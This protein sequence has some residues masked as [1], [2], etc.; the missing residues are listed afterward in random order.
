MV[1]VKRARNKL[2]PWTSP[3][4]VRRVVRTESTTVWNVWWKKSKVEA[5]GVGG[6]VSASYGQFQKIYR[7]WERIA[8]DLVSPFHAV[9]IFIVV[10]VKSFD[11][12]TSSQYGPHIGERNREKRDAARHACMH[13]RTRVP[14]RSRNRTFSCVRPVPGAACI[15]VNTVI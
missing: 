5:E 7:S 12:S 10:A 14:T 9:T 3:L 13:A 6:E 15:R 11:F 2:S 4:I 8:R 1:R